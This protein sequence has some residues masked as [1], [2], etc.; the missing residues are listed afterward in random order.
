VQRDDQVQQQMH[1]VRAAIELY[2]AQHQ[3]AAPDLSRGWT[4][5]TNPSDADGGTAQQPLFGPYLPKPPVNPLTGG[6]TVGTTP[7]AGVDWWWDSA[8]STVTALD[9]NGV[10]YVPTQQ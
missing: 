2:R 3:E 6:S 5:L 10:A 8:T 1:V 9:A 7:A 4:P